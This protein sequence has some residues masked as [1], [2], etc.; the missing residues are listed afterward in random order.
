MQSSSA[1]VHGSVHPQDAVMESA[2]ARV[3]ELL[4]RSDD[5]DKVELIT[6]RLQREKAAIDVQL[7]AEVKSHIDSTGGA[8]IKLADSKRIMGE[9]KGELV[10]IDKLCSE[11]QL[12]VRDFEKINRLANIHR[13]F[14]R[15]QEFADDMKSLHGRIQQVN[16]MI[17]DDCGDGQGGIEAQLDSRVPNLLTIHYMLSEMR[18][19]RDSAMFHAERASEDTRRTT[20]KHFAPLDPLIAKFDRVVEDVGGN[21]L[22]FIR[23]G[24][25]SLVVRLAK[26]IDLEER[27]DLK[28]TVLLEV[29]GKAKQNGHVNGNKTMSVTLGNN[30]APRAPRG[31]PTLF[32]RAMEKS[33]KDSFEACIESF[34]GDCQTLLEN[35]AWIYTDLELTRMELAAL[36]PKRWQIFDTVLKFY[37]VETHNLLDQ[38]LATDPDAQSILAILNYVKDY[39]DTMKKGFGVQKEQ[40]QPP[41]LDGKEN[42]LYDDYMKLIVNKL[43]E[44]MD[45]LA[46]TERQAF[47][48][49]DNAP[50]MDN[51]GR[52]ALQGEV[53][54]FKMIT[55]QIEVAADSQQGRILAGVVEECGNVLKER[56]ASWEAIMTK[57]VKKEIRVAEL[58][59]DKKKRKEAEKAQANGADDSDD[60]LQNNAGLVDYMI[61]LANDQIRG[62][63][64]TEALSSKV[65][66][67]VSQ[68][69]STQITST[70][71][72]V[73]DGYV[74]FAKLCTNSLIEII[75]SDLKPAFDILFETSTIGASAWYKGIPMSQ[76]TD[77]LA[78]YYGDVQSH[79]N[80]LLIEVFLDDL[81]DETVLHYLQALRSGKHHKVSLKL[82]K[83]SVQI[84]QDI[85][86]MYDFFDEHHSSREHVQQ[87]FKVFEHLLWILE[88]PIEE[89]GDK[90]TALKAE[91]WDCPLSFFEAV[92]NARKDIDS[93]VAKELIAVVRSEALLGGGPEEE[94]QPTI[95]GRYGRS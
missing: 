58:L 49:R 62:A 20:I 94:Q 16:D 45:N 48:N 77:T 57:E 5:L 35:L 73:S 60:E 92:V 59:R 7:K 34:P 39:Y 71:E 18:D 89:L 67:V 84:K 70:L 15:T 37:H 76:I 55:Q 4:K 95:M 38:V 40:L 78:E 8:V 29:N 53:I 75:F 2:V 52:Y 22:E 25:T 90:Y 87:V 54:T 66:P 47:I 42:D 46:T 17:E 31:Y 24:N 44:W 85:G 21:L 19:F 63:D 9:I 79:M 13:N 69:Y 50:E 64:Y 33:I 83:A 27:E 30:V 26:I 81:L 28:A 10:K 88:S 12:S 91:F 93:K 72:T 68:K 41:L 36:V 1:S 3:A 74:A 56:Q 86:K 23:S 80:P 61:A 65:A 43:N 51:D 14:I 82:P 11:S 32:L 6:Q